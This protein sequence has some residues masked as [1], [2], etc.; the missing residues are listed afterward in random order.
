M[1][2]KVVKQKF[3]VGGQPYFS[4]ERAEHAGTF[5]DGRYSGWL[6][7]YPIEG[8]LNDMSRIAGGVGS[9]QEVRNDKSAVR[10]DAARAGF[11]LWNPSLPPSAET[12]PV[13]VTGQEATELSHEIIDTAAGPAITPE[14]DQALRLLLARA[15]LLPER[16]EA[17]SKVAVASAL[18]ALQVGLSAVLNFSFPMANDAHRS[19]IHMVYLQGALCLAAFLASRSNASSVDVTPNF[20]TRLLDGVEADLVTKPFGLPPVVAEAFATFRQSRGSNVLQVVNS[21]KK[22]LPS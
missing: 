10:Y 6:G 14:A 15:S 22:D 4:I 11:A 5:V 17:L 19:E 8:T 20:F 16:E 9:R 1:K 13:L 21:G 7:G 12:L 3:T 18:Q 2:L